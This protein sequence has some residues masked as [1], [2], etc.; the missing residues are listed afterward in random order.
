MPGKYY[1]A[2]AHAGLAQAPI[3]RGIRLLCTLFSLLLPSQ[4]NA[5]FPWLEYRSKIVEDHSNFYAGSSLAVMAVGFAGA[6][7]L[8]YTDADR[9]IRNWY[10]DDIR[11]RG[12]D[13]FALFSKQF[14]EGY[15]LV[16]VI[17]TAWIAGNLTADTLPGSVLA[18]WGEN[19]LRS[20]MVGAPPMLFAQLATGGSRP[21]ETE[22]NSAWRPFQDDNGVSGHSFM[23]AIPFITAAKMTD[24]PLGKAGLYFCSTWTGWSR[25]NDNQHYTSQVLLGWMMAYMACTAVDRTNTTFRNYQVVP[26][27]MDDGLGMG[28]LYQY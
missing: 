21:G 10:Q 26:L 27:P 25:I 14:G 9:G 24:D 22:H 20:L 6:V 15:Y 28:V 4:A 11:S 17:A 1:G 8:A 23:G 12:T 16:P 13:N 7:P 19:G 5:E 18:E 3:A 2:S